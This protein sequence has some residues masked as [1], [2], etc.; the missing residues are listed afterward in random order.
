MSVGAA[1]AAVDDVARRWFSAQAEAADIE[2]RLAKVAQRVE[3]ADARAAS[4]REIAT[5]RAL[6]IYKGAGNSF[7][8]LLGSGD[9]L[10]SARRVALIDHAN[11]GS[12]AAIDKLGGVT[13]D[14]RA[15]QADLRAAR[16]RQTEVL[17]DLAGRRKDLE[18]AL[19]EAVSADRA[20]QA[21]AAASRLAAR[22]MTSTSRQSAPNAAGVSA[23]GPG[24]GS[25]TADPVPGETPAPAPPSAGTHPH[26]DDPFLACTRARESGGSYGAV[27]SAGYYGAYQF[28]PLTWDTS[29]SH[30]GRLELVGVLPSHA[31]EYDQDDLAWSLY[32]WQGKAPWGGH[33]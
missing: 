4:T 15:E 8:S 21:R 23:V 5:E 13:D 24:Q 1:R 11:A 30:A 14:L 22:T 20:A 19:A 31:S 16:T 12:N 17:A 26:H 6:Q 18:K 2:Q 29:A 25:R 32:Q 10:E 27:N 7:V 28:A 9:A 33:C 3:A